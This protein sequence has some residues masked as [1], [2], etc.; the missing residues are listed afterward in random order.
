MEST[1]SPSCLAND[2]QVQNALNPLLLHGNQG[3]GVIKLNFQG[4]EEVKSGGGCGSIGPVDVVG[5]GMPLP[6][7]VFKTSIGWFVC[8]SDS[9]YIIVGYGESWHWGWQQ[10]WRPQQQQRGRREG[11]S[12]F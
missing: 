8:D 3:K 9:G 4:Q 5:L 6:H 12:P 7:A 10:L 1:L 11:C 2:T